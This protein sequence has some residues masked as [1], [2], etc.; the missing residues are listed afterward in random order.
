MGLDVRF[1]AV[2]GHGL[3]HSPHPVADQDVCSIVIRTQGEEV[4]V[5]L[6]K[7][8]EVAGIFIGEIRSDW[9]IA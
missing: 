9:K 5:A 3:K 6:F 7:T 8:A 2:R 4:L 1:F